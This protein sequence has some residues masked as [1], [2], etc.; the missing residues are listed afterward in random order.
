MFCPNCGTKISIEQK[1]CRS[2][3]LGLEKV[4]ETLAD[5]LPVKLN[6]SLEQRKNKLERLGVAA[7]STF[8][9]GLLGIFLYSI[10]D[11]LLVQGKVL[12]ALGLIAA[13]I[14]LACGVLS[15]ILFAKA[16]DVEE[17]AKKQRIPVSGK[18]IDTTGKL[19][20]DKH[21]DGVPSVAEGTTELLLTDGPARAKRA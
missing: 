17:E 5:Q 18:P 13:L 7:L 9:V 8:G 6:E 3:G 20:P 15:V 14:I 19:S 10:A 11:K 4:A 21:V 16:K 2:C 12:A 1:F